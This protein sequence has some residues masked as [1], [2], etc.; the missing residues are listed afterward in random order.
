MS[1]FTRSA[2]PLD[3]N[4]LVLTSIRTCNASVDYS[5]TRHSLRVES[6]DMHFF[7]F[8]FDAKWV[9]ISPLTFS[10]WPLNST[11]SMP[12]RVWGIFFFRKSD[13]R[14][15]SNPQQVLIVFFFFSSLVKARLKSLLCTTLGIG[16]K[17]LVLFF[18]LASDAF[19]CSRWNCKLSVAWIECLMMPMPARWEPQ[20]GAKMGAAASSTT[21]NSGL[22]VKDGI[23]NGSLGL[24]LL[25][26]LSFFLIWFIG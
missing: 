8:F 4:M 17:L 16:A 23:E 24:M 10:Q 1:R 13:G 3:R 25:I 12:T 22:V 5:E 20:G 19:L 11:I 2:S 21:I 18:F 15:L 6:Q 9:V 7:F 26:S 14:W